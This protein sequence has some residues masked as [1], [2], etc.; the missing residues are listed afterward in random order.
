MDT[1]TERLI[2]RALA[3]RHGRKTT[4]LIAHRLS[5]LMHADRIL[6]L[7]H[8]RVIQT[9]SHAELVNQEGLY[10]RLWSIQTSLQQD[11]AGDPPAAAAEARAA[12]AQAE[13]P[14]HV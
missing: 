7:D 2:L 9:G 3:D 1:H 13:A 10:R 11:L 6:V 12:H 8:G 5:T 14:T 4:I